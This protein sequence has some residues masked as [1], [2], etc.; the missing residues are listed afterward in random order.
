[1][2]KPRSFPAAVPLP[3][4]R[5]LLAGGNWGGWTS[6]YKAFESEVYDL[7][8]DAWTLTPAMRHYREGATTGALLPSG[9][10]LVAGGQASDFLSIDHLDS[11]SSAEIFDEG[12]LPEASP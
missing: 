1:M 2:L 8:R 7:R 9:D 10:V 12:P 3:S 5:V 6:S 4:G 11:I